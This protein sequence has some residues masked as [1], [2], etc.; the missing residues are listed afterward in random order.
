VNGVCPTVYEVI[1]Q[2]SW[3]DG[4]SYSKTKDLEACRQRFSHISAIQSIPYSSNS[5]NSSR[6][7]QAPL[8]TGSVRCSQSVFE[9]LIERVDC[10]ET[11]IFKPFQQ[12]ESGATT[13][14]TQVL[15]FSKEIE[16]AGRNT[17]TL[18]V[19]SVKNVR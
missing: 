3:R 10:T 2:S 8:L 1:D 6:I 12:A 7:H 14:T 18:L 5:I 16:E 15:T 4:K 17:G 11:K 13:V 9:G 19:N